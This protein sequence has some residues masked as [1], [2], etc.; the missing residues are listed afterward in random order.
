MKKGKKR[1]MFSEK[2]NNLRGNHGITVYQ[3][4]LL[5]PS[6]FLI[7]FLCLLPD[8][9]PKGVEW[10]KMEERGWKMGMQGLFFSLAQTRVE[11]W[12]WVCTSSLNL[13]TILSSPLSNSFLGAWIGFVWS[14]C[15]VSK[16]CGEV[17]LSN[18]WCPLDFS[19]R[20]CCSHRGQR[21][22]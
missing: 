20:C 8:T 10:K 16:C 2:K 11:L 7:F 5:L 17:G 6:I 18:W 4:V 12:A 19:K 22:G 21:E 14:S 9:S 13:L 3:Y 1:P 15:G